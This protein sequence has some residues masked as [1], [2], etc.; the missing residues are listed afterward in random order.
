[1]MEVSEYLDNFW[2]NKTEFHGNS[3][4]NPESAYTTDYAGANSSQR[5][6]GRSRGG[7]RGARG[8]V[9]GRAC[10]SNIKCYGCGGMGHVKR[11]CPNVKDKKERKDR[12]KI[13]SA[14][15]ALPSNAQSANF[16]TNP[17]GVLLDSGAS[18]HMSC[19]RDFLQ[20]ISN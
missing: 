6:Q 10:Q 3:K 11:D 17:E 18:S 12:S 8:A 4:A 20:I 9:Q 1:M 13:G 15:F 5:G 19:R 2:K 16:C 14:F 7:S